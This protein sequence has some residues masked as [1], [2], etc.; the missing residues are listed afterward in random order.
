MT[1]A[2]LP[3]AGH[4]CPG[5]VLGTGM[6][7]RS[8][9]FFCAQARFPLPC[10]WRETDDAGRAA[11]TKERSLLSELGKGGGKNLSTPPAL[12]KLLMHVLR[13]WGVGLLPQRECGHRTFTQ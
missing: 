6:P 8:V 2:W 13:W 10:R 4:W 3:F 12:P 5:E 11:V 7:E 9:A 1:F